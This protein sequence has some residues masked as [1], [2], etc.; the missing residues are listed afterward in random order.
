MG[1]IILAV[2]PLLAGLLPVF[3][4]WLRRRVEKPEA[5]ARFELAVTECAALIDRIGRLER[6]GDLAGADALRR[7]LRDLADREHLPF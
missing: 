2:I 7:R 1:E 4:D 3:A 5:Q 6:A